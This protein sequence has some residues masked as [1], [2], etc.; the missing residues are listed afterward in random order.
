MLNRII[1]S[2]KVYY[3]ITDLEFL[4]GLSPY[5]MRKVLKEQ[6]IETTTLDGFGR[7][8]FVLEENVSAIEVDGKITI[9][10][11]TIDEKIKEKTVKKSTTKKTKAKKSSKKKN[12]VKELPND[13]AE[14]VESINE[15][16]PERQKDFDE[17]LEKGRAIGFKFYQADKMNI[18]NAI[19]AKHSIDLKTA[20]L[21]DIERMKPYV[22]DLEK[23]E[24]D[25]TGQISA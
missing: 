17:L 18:V 9:V 11:T 24:V 3:K 13:S 4:F 5:K 1:F 20:T 14:K 7:S 16:D 21:D 25:L 12:E 2:N 6:N 15:Q 22:A 23:A 19:G 10:K 8:K